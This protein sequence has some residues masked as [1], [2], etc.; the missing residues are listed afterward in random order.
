MRTFQKNM[1]TSLYFKNLQ[2]EF[3][4][5]LQEGKSNFN[6]PASLLK[7][8][9]GQ[10]LWL[11][12]YNICT[13]LI[14]NK[15][16]TFKFMVEYYKKYAKTFLTFFSTSLNYPITIKTSPSITESPL[17]LP[18]D[19]TVPALSASMLFS[20]FMASRISTR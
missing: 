10:P 13:N 18:I 14:T 8:V 16:N 3:E 7:Y 15:L 5:N 6:T 20:I 9:K 2:F 19:T 4:F 11:P 12:F 1:I 17:F